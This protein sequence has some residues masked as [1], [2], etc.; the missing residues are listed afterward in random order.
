MALSGSVSTSTYDGYGVTMTWTATQSV[1]NNTST[2]KWTLK[3]FGGT[4]NYYYR[5]GPITLTINGSTAYSWSDR[6]NLWG[7]GGWS[8][9]GTTTIAHNSDG[10]KSFNVSISVAIYSTSVNCTGSK[11]FTLNSIARTPTAPTACTFSAGD[12]NYWPYGSVATISWS[13]ATGYITGY[14]VQQWYSGAGSWTAYNKPSGT[15]TTVTYLS[16]TY[17]AGETYKFRVRALNGS[18]ASAWKESNTLTFAG[19]M[20]IKQAGSWTTGSV[21]INVNGTWT[22]AK[23]VWVNVNGTWKKS[24]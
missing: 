14:E 16:K 11:T 2:I 1:A 17:K 4:S 6:F 9:S 18:L 23:Q 5:A 24:R 7:A 22:R 15:S 10:T 3:S 21:W 8:Q 20:R 13:G 12:G 19:G